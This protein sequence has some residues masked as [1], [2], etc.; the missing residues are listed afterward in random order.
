[1]ELLQVAI[2]QHAIPGQ[3]IVLIGHSLGCSLSA[4]VATAQHSET[5]G[6][7]DFLGLIGICPP[8][9]MRAGRKANIL[10]LLLYIPDPI[11][12]VFRAWDRRGGPLSASVS[13]FVGKEADIEV[14]KLQERFNSQ[15]RTPVYRRIAWG[16]FS[17]GSKV[18]GMA[19]LDTWSALR[20]S[21]F[22][23]GGEADQ[24]TKAEAVG[25]IAESIQQA[26]V[27]SREDGTIIDGFKG[28]FSNSTTVFPHLSGPAEHADPEGISIYTHRLRVVLKTSTLPSPASHG[29]LYDP[30]TSRTLSGLIQAFLSAHIDSRLSL[31]FQLQ[32]LTTEGKWDVKN[33]EKWRHVPPVSQS[34]GGIFRAMKTLREVDTVHSPEQ[35]ARHWKG[36]LKAVVDISHDSPV[37]DPKGLEDEGIQYHKF[38]TVSKIPPTRDEIKEF[39]VLIDRIRAAGTDSQSNHTDPERVLPSEQRGDEHAER[40]R[41]IGVHCHYGFNRTGFFIC[42]Y[43]IEREHFSVQAAVD[44]FA[45]NRPP[46]IK[47][48]HFLDELFVRYCIGLKRA[49]TL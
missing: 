39:K 33:L 16:L 46:G 20:I 13:R 14:K 10:R 40:T 1:M 28:R 27:E 3:G 29:L 38:P 2:A 26:R 15:S 12:N 49:P 31:A 42:S 5:I 48:P 25:Q 34:I 35:F 32:H 23:I 4:L 37:Y 18:P 17:H 21:L 44:E 9:E 30:A 45:A 6:R 7:L 11:F 36:K 43:L 22:L 24:V 19:T 41:S 47:H 8:P